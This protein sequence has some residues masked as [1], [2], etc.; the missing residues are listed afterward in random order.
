M[1]KGERLASSRTML[2]ILLIRHGECEM[3]LALADKVGGRSNASPLTPLGERQSTH[4]GAHLKRTL[5]ASGA[6]PSDLRCFC[7]TAVR[8]VDT[9]RRALEAAGTGPVDWVVASEDLLEMHMGEW[10][11]G[12]RAECYTPATLQLIAEDTHNF[13]PPGGESQKAV[14]Q[15]M[16]HFLSTTVLP[17]AQESGLPSLV[18][19]HGMAFKCVLR[20]VLDS[21]PSMTRKFALHNTSI[22][23]L[24]WVPEEVAVDG[25]LQP[26]FH[27]L[28][29]NDTAHLL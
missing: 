8:A 27:I 18:F 16:M 19:G 28:R 29:V 2:R 14:E 26:G 9:A 21:S 17:A 5:L 4:L 22:T 12:M 25:G 6:S 13:A 11:G 23:E 10:E 7:S 3:N 24:G 15:R 20:H 1:I